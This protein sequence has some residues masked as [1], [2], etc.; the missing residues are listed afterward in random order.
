MKYIVKLWFTG[1]FTD[2]VLA[3]DSSDAV[4]QVEKSL[5]DACPFVKELEDYDYSLVEEDEEAEKDETTE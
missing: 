2:T 5:R 3:K 1:T 4:Q